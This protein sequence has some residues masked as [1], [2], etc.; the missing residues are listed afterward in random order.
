LGNPK[1]LGKQVLCLLDSLLFDSLRELLNDR[2]TRFE[3]T[4][5]EF[6]KTRDY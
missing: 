2:S 1:G 5:V 6:Y 3:N 4:R